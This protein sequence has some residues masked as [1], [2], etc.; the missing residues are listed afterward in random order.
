MLKTEGYQEMRSRHYGR[1]WGR[2]HMSIIQTYSVTL[3]RVDP[4]A[5]PRANFSTE[6]RAPDSV[7]AMRMAEAQFPG[8][9]ATTAGAILGR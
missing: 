6:V 9:K 5:G 7:S 2:I 4:N 8:Y 1:F 3:T